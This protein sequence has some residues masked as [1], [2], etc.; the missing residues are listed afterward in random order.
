LP[1]GAPNRGRRCSRGDDR[2]RDSRCC[3]RVQ[4]QFAERRSQIGF[5]QPRRIERNRQEG[6][7]YRKT[8]ASAVNNMRSVRSAANQSNID[9]ITAELGRRAGDAG[10]AKRLKALD[11]KRLG[12]IASDAKNARRKKA[13]PT[14]ICDV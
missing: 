4:Q 3:N 13:K 8:T 12:A 11:Q 10:E 2:T 7:D 5:L 14:A 1:T 9:S 6:I